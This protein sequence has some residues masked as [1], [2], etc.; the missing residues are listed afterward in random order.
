MIIAPSDHEPLSAGSVIT[1][2]IRTLRQRPSIGAVGTSVLGLLR[3][4]QSTGNERSVR[5]L[6]VLAAQEA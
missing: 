2:K 5:K 6:A 4:Q 1:G 3:S